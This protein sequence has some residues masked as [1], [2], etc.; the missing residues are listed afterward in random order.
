M[1]TTT[2]KTD[3]E[4]LEFRTP[5]GYWRTNDGRRVLVLWTD[6]WQ[7]KF[8]NLYQYIQTLATATES[9]LE[10]QRSVATPAA[11]T[12]S[13][14][15]L[16]LES[17]PSLLGADDASAALRIGPPSAAADDLAGLLG[18]PPGVAFE[19]FAALM[20][21]PPAPLA[22]DTILA[23]GYSA[24]SPGDPVGTTDL[25][26]KMMGLAHSFTPLVTG[27]A[28]IT[29]TGVISNGTATD[30]AAVQL[31]YGTGAAPANGDALTG[32]TLGG[33]KEVTQFLAAQKIPFTVHFL[34]T[35]LAIGTAHWIDVGLKAL[36]LGQANIYG[37]DIVARE[38]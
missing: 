10:A 1:P 12:D 19:E 7:R 33:Y 6:E 37:I 29:I 32:T 14:D 20:G 13:S 17:G 27:R 16:L 21:S 9:I 34:V 25:A 31:R 35:G 3:L 15:A 28:V 18:M 36:T 23:L 38:F 11:G 4:P 22:L 5:M 26:G 24:S 2:A 30:G 8:R